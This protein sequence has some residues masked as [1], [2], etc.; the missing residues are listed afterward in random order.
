MGKIEDFFGKKPIVPSVK[1]PNSEKYIRQ[2]L[3]YFCGKDYSWL[4]VY[5]EV[6]KWAENNQGKG[7]FLMGDCGTGKT[8]LTSRILLPLI[9]YFWQK[10]HL[11]DSKY[12]L[13][14]FSALNMQSA[15][16]N[17]GNILVDDVGIEDISNS[18]GEK[19]DYFARLMDKVEYEGRLIICT[20]NL[21]PDEL[22]AKYGM[23]VWDRIVA[24]TIPLIFNN[25]GKS[26][27]R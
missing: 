15:F 23:R 27:R 9:N 11:G 1:I 2:G 10:E 19:V 3:G 7:L 18:F 5:D 17:P 24:M 6:V 20:S 8:L 16:E 22:K 14:R 25:G 12:W 21:T 26:L 4:P 13:V